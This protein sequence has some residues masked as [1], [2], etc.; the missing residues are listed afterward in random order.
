MTLIHT[1]M[2]IPLDPVHNL[3]SFL[4]RLVHQFEQAYE[5]VHYPQTTF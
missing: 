5:G 1:A 4:T 2:E 3:V